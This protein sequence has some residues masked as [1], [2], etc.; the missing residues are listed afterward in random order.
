MG[1]A[2]PKA[3]GAAAAIALAV[4][5]VLA[6]C[7]SE[8][9]PASTQTVASLPAGTAERLARQSERIADQLDAGD[10]CT[11][12]HSADDLAAAVDGA[13]VPAELRSELDGAAESL[14][15]SVNCPPPP[16]PPEDEKKQEEEKKKEKDENHGGDE[17]DSGPPGQGGEL[18]P[19]QKKK[20]EE[21]K[22]NQ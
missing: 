13:D 14:V 16:E 12:A 11:A 8:E 20:Y 6:A 17:S 4:A 19:G 21:A 7:G 10:T 5:V 22:L 9:D 1:M 15:D 3:M 2:N 18:P